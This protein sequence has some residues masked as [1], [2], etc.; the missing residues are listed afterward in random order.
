[1]NGSVLWIAQDRPS[2]ADSV[3][4][5][6]LDA[7]ERLASFPK[8]GR[9]G[10]AAGTREWV[11]HGLPYIIVYQVDD[12]LDELTMTAVFHAARNR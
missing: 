9:L 7:T 3:I 1:L 2:A 5:R 4:S 6:I 10:A 12:A 8:M 11:V